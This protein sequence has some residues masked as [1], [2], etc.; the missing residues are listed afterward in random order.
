MCGGVCGWAESEERKMKNENKTLNP[1][2]VCNFYFLILGF[3]SC[4]STRSRSA[5]PVGILVTD[6]FRNRTFNCVRLADFFLSSI[7]FDRFQSFDEI[8]LSITECSIIDVGTPQSLFIPSSPWW[9]RKQLTWL[10]SS[11]SQRYDI[12]AN[13]LQSV[14]LFWLTCFT[15][16]YLYAKKFVFSWPHT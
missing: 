4:S 8:R 15:E 1:S 10:S 6:P 11:G 3:V 13:P 2:P 5:I 14:M 7:L 9:S 12:L 16:L